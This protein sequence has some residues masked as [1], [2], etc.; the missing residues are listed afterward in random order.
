MLSKPHDG[1]FFHCFKTFERSEVD[2]E[3]AKFELAY[4][5]PV[6]C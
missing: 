2:V 3:D 6:S 4:F 1:G 5:G